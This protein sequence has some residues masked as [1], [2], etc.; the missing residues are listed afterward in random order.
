MRKGMALSEKSALLPAKWSLCASANRPE[1]TNTDNVTGGAD[2]DLRNHYGRDR[3]QGVL[4]G[5]RRVLGKESRELGHAVRTDRAR[6]ECLADE[7]EERL[8][9]GHRERDVLTETRCRG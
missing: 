3:L 6:L 2:A 4:T 9:R 1:R 7:L 5:D 8:S